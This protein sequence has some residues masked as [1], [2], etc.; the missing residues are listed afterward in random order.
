M[1]QKFGVAKRLEKRPMKLKFMTRQKSSINLISGIFENY[2]LT[3]FKDKR[4]GFGIEINLVC[5][6]EGFIRGCSVF[7]NYVDRILG[8]FEI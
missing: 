4:Y 6:L 7:T 5:I 2:R 8:I 1:Y 3:F